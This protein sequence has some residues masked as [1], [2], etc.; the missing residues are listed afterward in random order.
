MEFLKRYFKCIYQRKI[1][2]VVLLVIG[3]AIGIIASYRIY[4]PEHEYYKVS[5]NA[6]NLSDITK[7]S[8]QAAKDKIQEIRDNGKY[9]ILNDYKYEV[10]GAISAEE[11]GDSKIII[12]YI[13]DTTSIVYGAL[14]TNVFVENGT[15][16]IILDDYWLYPYGGE[17]SSKNG[18]VTV[19]SN[20]EVTTYE[21]VSD[22]KYHYSYSSFSYIRVKK[23]NKTSYVKSNSDGTYT[24]YMQQ[25]Y[26]NSWQQARRFMVRYI[27]YIASDYTYIL[28]DTST[29]TTTSITT[30]TK[31]SNI[32]G[33]VEGTNL[34]IWAL[35]GASAGI[36]LDLI[37]GLPPGLY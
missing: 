1:L 21:A 19:T 28:N 33:E 35:V 27:S 10:P 12:T 7:D 26:F 20:G 11:Q 8:L 6:T 18:I 22:L 13:D 23:L 16:Y 30:A 3:A 9:V 4:N 25:R 14:D 36:V 32:L 2:F 5:F 34:Y 37:L 29:P 15:E 24:L 17:L 31:A